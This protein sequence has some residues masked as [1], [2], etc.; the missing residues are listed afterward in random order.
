MSYDEFYLQDVELAKFYRQAYEM[1]EDRKNSHLWLQGMYV[2]DAIS[3]S[4][5]NVFCRKSGQQAT[6]YPSKPYPLTDK[7]KE[8]DQQLTIEEEQ[9]KAKVWMNTLVNSYE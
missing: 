5:Y 4:L 8:V 2:Y 3:T 7:Q 6:S 9:A 1:K